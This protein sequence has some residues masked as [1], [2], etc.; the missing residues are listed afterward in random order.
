[1]NFYMQLL[2]QF[3]NKYNEEDLKKPAVI[4]SPHFDDETHGCGGTIIKKKHAGAEVTIV[5]MT[6]GSKSHNHLIAEDELKAIRKSEGLAASRSLGLAANNVLYLDF[7]DSRLNEHT[8][9]AIA[10]VTEILLNKTPDEIFV[11]HNREPAIWSLDHFTTNRIVMSAL[12]GYNREIIVYEYPIWMWYDLLRINLPFDTP[13]RIMIS[14]KQDLISRLS[15]LK[16]FRC[17]VYIGDILKLK[18]AALN[19]HKSQMT[20]LN[21]D[22]EWKTLRDVANGEFLKCFFQ[23]YELFHRSMFH[24]NRNLSGDCFRSD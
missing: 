11:P 1:M 4:F 5:F 9:S 24:E 20:Q 12:R 8:T 10:K 7:E 22:P 16:D 19:Q 6:D 15:M 21:L 2:Q 3:S 18:N 23:N 17:S 13:K 14:L